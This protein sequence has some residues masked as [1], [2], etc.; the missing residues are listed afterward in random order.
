[1]MTTKAKFNI[2]KKGEFQASLPA[3][4]GHRFI[5][6]GEDCITKETCAR[7]NRIHKEHA[8]HRNN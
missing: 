8:S 2:D 7:W 6:A 1:M 5:C 4:N 3:A